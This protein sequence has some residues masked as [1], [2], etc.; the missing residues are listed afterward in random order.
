MGIRQVTPP[1]EVNRYLEDEI[2]RR[3][4]VIINT[5]NRVGMQCVKVARDIS[6]PNTFLDQTGNLRSSIGYAVLIDGKID[7]MSSFGPV[8]N[9]TEGKKTGVNLINELAQKYSRG[10]VLV[11]VAG[12]NYA[13]YVETKRDVLKSSELKAKVLLPQML[14]KLG[15]K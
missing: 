9:G 8:K 10:I 13:S 6:K 5:L 2:K 12:M 15:L 4:Q 3:V 1:H 7:K 14:K 11:V